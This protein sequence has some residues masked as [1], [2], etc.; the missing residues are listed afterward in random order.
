[1]T[2]DD[3]LLKL[4]QNPEQIEFSETMDVIDDN[5]NFTPA[6]FSNGD[7]LNE[8]NQNNGSCKI[9]AFGLLNSLNEHQTLA[10]FGSY[11]RDDVLAHPESNDHQNIR[12]FIKS[13]WDGIH[14]SSA[15]LL[16]K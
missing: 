6:K 10:C 5:Y 12:N 16:E 8:E 2:I 15:A 4:D 9:F 14:F 1:M 11:Y 7:T 3:F 13:G